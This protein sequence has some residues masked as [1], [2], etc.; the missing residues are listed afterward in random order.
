MHKSLTVGPLQQKRDC[1][2]KVMY[3]K[4]KAEGNSDVLQLVPEPALILALTVLSCQ[5]YLFTI[6]LN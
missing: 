4:Q 3:L 5:Y 1:S 6:V 2:V